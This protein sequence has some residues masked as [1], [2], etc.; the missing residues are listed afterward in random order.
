MVAAQVIRVKP[1]GRE[2]PQTVA[3]LLGLQRSEPCAVQIRVLAMQQ[4]LDAGPKPVF[5]GGKRKADHVAGG[6][7]WRGCVPL[8][9]H[10]RNKIGTDADPVR[11]R[12]L[13]NARKA[14][15]MYGHPAPCRRALLHQQAQV[16][17]PRQIAFH[18]AFVD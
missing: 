12:H 6:D 16:A 7:G 18:A 5:L 10:P 3:V 14:K 8:P 13:D 11:S 4:R 1:A 17:Q 2:Q 9:F 15:A